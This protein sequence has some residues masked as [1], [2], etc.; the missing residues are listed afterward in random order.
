MCFS[1]QCRISRRHALHRSSVLLIFVSRR[2]GEIDTRTCAFHRLPRPHSA[3]TAQTRQKRQVNSLCKKKAVIPCPEVSCSIDA[4]R[5]QVS[6]ITLQKLRH[7]HPRRRPL[8]F[9]RELLYMRAHLDWHLE[10]CHRFLPIAARRVSRRL[11]LA[12]ILIAPT[13]KQ[14]KAASNL[15]PCWSLEALWSIV[16]RPMTTLQ[17]Q[18]ETI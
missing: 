1:H 16:A 14:H 9:R 11:A 18:A 8:M 15:L 10:R 12:S 4:P 7:P 17:C 2:K 13:T 6:T 5:S 3:H